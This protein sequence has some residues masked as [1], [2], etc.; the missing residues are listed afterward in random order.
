MERHNYR[1]LDIWAE[2][3]WQECLIDVLCPAWRR[4]GRGIVAAGGDRGAV[5]A[6]VAA[7]TGPRRR[8]NELKRGQEAV[9]Y[10]WEDYVH[11]HT[12]PRFEK[13]FGVKV[14]YDTFRN[15]QLSRNPSRRQSMM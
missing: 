8:W 6:G 4:L 3:L 9:R 2:A 12:I 7:E 11:P 13:E 10:N 5:Y 1:Q 14:T 15:E